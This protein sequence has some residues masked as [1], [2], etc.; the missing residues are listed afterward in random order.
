MQQ[1]VVWINLIDGFVEQF[2]GQKWWPAIAARFFFKTKKLI[3][4]RGF[5]FKKYYNGML[6][7]KET[8]AINSYV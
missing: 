8:V 3:A 6:Y 2:W 7:Q 1:S 5:G 4:E